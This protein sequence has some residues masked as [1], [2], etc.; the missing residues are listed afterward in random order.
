MAVNELISKLEASLKKINELELLV[1]DLNDFRENINLPLHWVNGSGVI[2][3]ANKAE[4][5]FLGYT[6]E[7]YIG[8]HISNFYEDKSLVED[9]LNRLIKKE[10]LNDY[11]ARLISKSG[12]VK[13]VLINS[14]VRFEGD[15]FIHTRCFTKDM[16]AIKASEEQKEDLIRDLREENMQLKSALDFVQK[17]TSVASN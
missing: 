17:G 14:N 2:I 15:R 7:E 5:D 11:Q 16:T 13:T 1:E 8:N 9:I 3:W 6:Q 10:V 4:L 12:E